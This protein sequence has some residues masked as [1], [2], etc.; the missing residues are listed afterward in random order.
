VKSRE[1]PKGWE[2]KKLGD[3]GKII[4]GVTYKSEEARDEPRENFIPILRAMNI[5]GELNF[6]DL[7]FVPS[8]RVSKEQF[9]KADDIVIAMSSGSKVIVG[10]TA[11]A[12]QDY[13]GSFGA[14]CAV[15]R[16]NENID[17]KYVGL[18]FQT[19]NYRALISHL[20]RGANIN[21][22]RK[23]NFKSMLIPIPPL[24]IQRQIVAVL[25][26]AEAVSRQRQEA[27]ALTE[28]LF[29]SVF[30]E[31]FG[32]PV[33]NERGW[34]ARKLKD[35]SEVV[36]GVTKG[37]KFNGKPTVFVPYL[38]V[39]NVQDGFLDLTEIKD[40]EVLDSDI[41]KF[42]LKKGDI[43]L[44]EGGDRDKLGRGHVWYEEIP[45][46]IHQNH[47]FRVRLNEKVLN[48]EFFSFLIGSAYGKKYFAKSAKQTTGIASINSTQL[49]NFPALLPPLALQQQFARVVESV[50][51][52]RERQVASGQQIEGLC[53]GL[54]QR[55]F[56]GEIA[57]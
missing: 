4:S 21:N 41:E 3:I 40:I 1:L 48:P 52:I 33:S 20:S 13:Q 26:K 44:T 6:N 49:K 56:A 39:A 8:E 31:L 51:R 25:E 12:K 2:W 11:Q 37:R 46:C 50:E 10:K 7:V 36:S 45:L 17:K 38:R 43:I 22:L 47:I 5:N 19:P 16:C 57:T 53:E 14:F 28:V 34:E 18:F 24:N 42:Q 55:A 29:Q 23:D 35:I 9:I 32:D 54:M 27:D 15:F 30:R